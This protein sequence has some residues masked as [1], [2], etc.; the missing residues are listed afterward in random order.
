LF[1]FQCSNHNHQVFNLA[2]VFH[3]PFSAVH[4]QKTAFRQYLIVVLHGPFIFA[5]TFDNHTSSNEQ[6]SANMRNKTI[7][8]TLL[9]A[10]TLTVTFLVFQSSVRAGKDS[11]NKES[12]DRSCQK[13]ENNGK[14]IWENLSHQFFSSF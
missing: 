3:P 7:I 6:K 8:G 12:L 9:L 2:R 10:F 5:V 1:N 14:M 13:K 11:S 4:W